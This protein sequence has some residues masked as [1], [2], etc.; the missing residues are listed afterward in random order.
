M[1]ADVIRLSGRLSAK[2]LQGRVSF[3]LG[4]NCR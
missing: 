1:V 4:A 3:V 2:G